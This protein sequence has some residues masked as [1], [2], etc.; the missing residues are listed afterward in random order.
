MKE[1]NKKLKAAKIAAQAPT[2]AAPVAKKGG[3]K[4]KAAQSTGR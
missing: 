2:K 1:R 4:N 3:A